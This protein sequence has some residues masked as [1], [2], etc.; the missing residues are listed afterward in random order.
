MPGVVIHAVALEMMLNGFGFYEVKGIWY[1]LIVLFVLAVH[2]VLFAVILDRLETKIKKRFPNKKVHFFLQKG[3]LW[4]VFSAWVVLLVYVCVKLMSAGI[5]LNANNLIF[6]IVL[7]AAAIGL[8][9][10]YIQYQTK[11]TNEPT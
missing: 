3:T 10:E 8:Q 1:A 6:H 9:Q 11:K 5:Y 2:F 7:F 4:I